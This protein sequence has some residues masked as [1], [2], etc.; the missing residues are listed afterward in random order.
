MRDYK[1]PPAPETSLSPEFAYRG[2]ETLNTRTSLAAVGAH[3]KEKNTPRGKTSPPLRTVR[4]DAM[5][6]SSPRQKSP[7]LGRKIRDNYAR[8]LSSANKPKQNAATLNEDAINQAPSTSTT[9]ICRN[10]LS[11]GILDKLQKANYISTIDLDQALYQIT[12]DEK[13]EE[14]TA[15]TV[16]GRGLFQF[17]RMP[18]RLTNAPATFQRLIDKV[19]DP[20]LEP[21]AFAYLDDVIIASETFEDH[22]KWLK[23]V[24]D[25]LAAAGLSVNLEKC[26]FFRS[27]IKYVGFL[28][29]N[30]GVKVDPNKVAPILDLPAPRNIRKLWSFLDSARWDRRS[31]LNFATVAKPLFWLLKKAQPFDWQEEQKAAFQ[32][33]KTALTTAPVIARPDFA[34]PFTFHT[35]ASFTGVGAVLT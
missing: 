12:L 27:V 17:T 24:L 18:F 31:L 2:E 25:K 6:H 1:P 10:C 20:E 34:H 28:N 32:A 5:S 13:R 15:F 30:K 3:I 14:D 7:K 29:S 33:I 8:R 35:D 19:I 16:P 9:I 23:E 22:L 4:C 11:Y 21:H 26:Q